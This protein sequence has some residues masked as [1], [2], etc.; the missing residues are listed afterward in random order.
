MKYTKEEKEESRKQLR[1]WIKPGDTIYTILR[2]VS[3]S[4]MYRVI[5][6]CKMDNEGQMIWL[7]FYASKL[8]EGYDYNHNGCKTRGC[9]M[10]MGFNL[11]YNLGYQ[12]YPDGF[13]CSGEHCPSNDHSNSPYPKR[14]AN[15]MHHKDG[16]Y[17][18]NQRWL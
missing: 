7:D 6:L 13:E 18:L 12:L 9:G 10:D 1:E 5:T 15:S 8:L 2:H 11:V 16:G 4:G 14:T 3:R 17:A